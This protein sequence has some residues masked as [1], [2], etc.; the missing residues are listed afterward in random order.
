MKQKLVLI[1]AGGMGLLAFVLTHVYLKGELEKIYENATRISVVVARE[2]LPAGTELTLENMDVISVFEASVGRQVFRADQRELL[3]GRTLRYP[4]QR[5]DMISWVHVGANLDEITGLAPAIRAGMRAISI[6]VSPETAVSGL[7]RPND[8]V[9]ILGTFS[10]ISERN[11][12]ELETVTLTVLQDVTVLATGQET[13]RQE[14]EV[15][16]A[17]RRRGSYNTVTIAVFPQEAELIAFAMN[18]KGSLTLT[19][20]NPTDTSV[21][22]RGDPVNFDH[23]QRELPT[24]NESRQRILQELRGG[25]PAPLNGR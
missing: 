25:G 7:I 5:G 14:L 21:P 16:G 9:D 18:T 4:L 23:L 1:I 17:S 22:V 12:A 24:L 3:Q 8:R 15:T 11:P 19:L 10:F 13:A 2:S 6:P 20:R